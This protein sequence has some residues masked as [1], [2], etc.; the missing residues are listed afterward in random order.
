M[1]L[2]RGWGQADLDLILVRNTK[3]RAVCLTYIRTDLPTETYAIRHNLLKSATK[4][5]VIIKLSKYKIYNPRAKLIA[6]H[7]SLPLVISSGA[8]EPTLL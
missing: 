8:R 5:V 2:G 4:F 6:I 7:N 3:E 1:Q